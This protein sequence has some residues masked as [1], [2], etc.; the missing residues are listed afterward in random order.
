MVLHVLLRGHPWGQTQP[1]RPLQ[2][3]TLVVDAPGPVP[4]C[5]RRKSPAPVLWHCT[6]MATCEPGTASLPSCWECQASPHVIGPGVGARQDQEFIIVEFV[7]DAPAQHGAVLSCYRKPLGSK[8]T[9]SP[10]IHAPS[11]NSRL[12]IQVHG[13]RSSALRRRQEKPLLVHPTCSHLND[14][15]SP[16]R[17]PEYSNNAEGHRNC[18]S[19]TN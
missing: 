5:C 11:L 19:D 16:L 12:F 6:E 1:V 18:F 10:A 9:R 2:V 13:L 17:Q 14:R 4:R 7:S 8:M 15:I 3:Q